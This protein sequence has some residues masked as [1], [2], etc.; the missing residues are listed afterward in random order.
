MT[1]DQEMER[2]V[3]SWLEPGL[4]TLTDDVLDPVLDQLPA[5]PQRRPIWSLRRFHHVGT[6]AKFSLAAAALVVVAVIGFNLA[7]RSGQP[8][9]GNS[10]TSTPPSS[11]EPSTGCHELDAGPYNTEAGQIGINATL[12]DGWF[13]H[14][15]TFTIYNKPCGF[16]PTA[17]MLI[18][19][20]DQVYADACDWQNSEVIDVRT[21]AAVTAALAGQAGR[22]TTQPT[23]T[24]VGGY[25]ASRFDF[26]PARCAQVDGTNTALWPGPEGLAEP[27]LDVGTVLTVYVVDVDGTTLAIAAIHSGELPALKTDLEAIVNSL[28]MTPR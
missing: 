10:P 2:I 8:I 11:A 23:A 13:G 26:V 20:V 22:P 3:R 4:T 15:D 14:S 25:P 5:T 1:T 16:G 7:S 6:F 21:P 27:T 12:P 24:T 28:Q 17:W 18:V 9:V 19:P